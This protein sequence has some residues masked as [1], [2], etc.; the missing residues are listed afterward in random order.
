MWKS[1]LLLFL[2]LTTALSANAKTVVYTDSLYPSVHCSSD[3]NVVWLDAPEQFQQKTFAYL[4]GHDVK[5]LI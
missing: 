5:A 4:S 3:I 2:G 1:G